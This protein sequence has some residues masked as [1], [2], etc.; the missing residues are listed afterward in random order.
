MLPHAKSLSRTR[1]TV[2]FAIGACAA[3]LLAVPGT[4]FAE[5]AS[6]GGVKS[7][8]LTAV[9]QNTTSG[10]PIVTAWENFNGTNGTNINGTTTD[11]G[12][13]TW[14]AVRGTWRIFGNQADADNGDVAL[15]VDASTPHQAVEA[16]VSRGGTTFDIGVVFNMNSTG[17]EFIT[18]ELTSNSNGRLEMWRYNGGWTLLASAANLYTGPASGWPTSANLRVSAVGGNVTVYLDGTQQISHTLSGA[19][20]TTFKNANHQYFGLY[21]YFDGNSRWDDFHI[22]A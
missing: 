21:S 10:A 2:R 7:A 4:T 22:D 11:G 8:N 1:R 3:M 15:V 19:D 17:T 16:T 5:A 18:T 20:Q 14:L 13:K 9:R 6:L 12:S